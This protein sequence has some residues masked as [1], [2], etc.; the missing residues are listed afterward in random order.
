MR[1][2]AL[3]LAATRVL[4]EYLLAGPL[5][6]EFLGNAGGFSGSRIWKIHNP[7]QVLCLKAWPPGH[8]RDDQLAQIHRWMTTAREAGLEFVPAVFRSNSGQSFF[9]AEGRHWDLTEWMPGRTDLGSNPRAAKVEAALAAL[10]RLHRAWGSESL[11]GIPPSVTRRLEMA[12][13]WQALVRTGWRPDFRRTDR[14]PV[15]D[16]ASAAWQRL[17]RLVPLVE[18]FLAPWRRPFRLQPCLCDIWHEHVLFDGDRVSG[19]I[20]YGAMR[21]DHLAADLARLLGSVTSLDHDTFSRGLNAYQQVARLANE[22]VG[23]VHA[24]DVT[25]TALGAANWLRWLYLENR[26]YQDID[27]IAQRMRSLVNRL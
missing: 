24:L 25:G 12:A 13:E 15:A 16:L 4:G 23:F 1:D 22:E 21:F 8:T 18:H 26:H 3:E 2:E 19:I 7:T 20:D 9:S 27:A 14:A 6:R 10:A 5:R 17:P 11:I